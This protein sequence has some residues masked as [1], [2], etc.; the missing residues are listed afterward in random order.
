MERQEMDGKLIT[1]ALR[2]LRPRMVAH[3]IKLPFLKYYG[4]R[5]SIIL[6]Q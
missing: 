4:F 1:K 5:D 6:F 3:M 2:G